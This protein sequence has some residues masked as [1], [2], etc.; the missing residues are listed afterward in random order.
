MILITFNDLKISSLMTPHEWIKHQNDHS[1][2]ALA[3]IPLWYVTL[4]THHSPTLNK[5]QIAHKKIVWGHSQCNCRGKI[6]DSG[7]H[8]C[9]CLTLGSFTLS[10]GRRKKCRDV[11]N[12]ALNL[13]LGFLQQEIW[14][15]FQH[16]RKATLVGRTR[17]TYPRVVHYKSK[18]RG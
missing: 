13:A 11:I 4:S 8:C 10:V 17:S 3:S 5:T 12:W 14:Q 15:P 6:V 1:H 2:N 18:W 16:D 9:W 7:W